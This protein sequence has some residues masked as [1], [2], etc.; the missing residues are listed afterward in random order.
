MGRRGL[1]LLAVVSMDGE[2]VYQWWRRQAQDAG[3]SRFRWRLQG[4]WGWLVGALRSDATPV[5]AAPGAPHAAHAYVE[6][7]AGGTGQSN[8]NAA[9]VPSG[10]SSSSSISTGDHS[11]R[12]SMR[13]VEELPRSQLVRYDLRSLCSSR[14]LQEEVLRCFRKVG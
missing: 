8:D 10:S 1:P 14:L 3:G 5:C 12:G 7:P 11:G 4:L 9:V 13:V 2:R 6:T